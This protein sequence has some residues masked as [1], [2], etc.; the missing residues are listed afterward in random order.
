[1]PPLTNFFYIP[2]ATNLLREREE[3]VRLLELDREQLRGNLASL[4]ASHDELNRHL[5]AHNRWALELEQNWKAAADRAVELQDILQREQAAW[6]EIAAAYQTKVQDLERENREKTQ[7]A[8]DTERHLSADLAA[9]CAE[10]AEAVRLLDQAEATV[11]ERTEWAR[12]L[13]RRLAEVARS[14]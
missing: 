11:T 13:E 4:Q 9:K 1:L 14:R 3:H 6:A 5:E 7:W 8:L 2:R 12:S 10:L